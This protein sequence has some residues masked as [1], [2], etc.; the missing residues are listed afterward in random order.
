[1]IDRS[2]IAQST[3]IMNSVVAQSDLYI[4]YGIR[5]Y[6]PLMVSVVRNVS[7]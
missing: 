3:D 6:H 2:I 7:C 5:M 4:N 1:M